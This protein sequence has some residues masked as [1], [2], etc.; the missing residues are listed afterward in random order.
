MCGLAGVFH[1]AGSDAPDD[2]EVVR[3]MTRVLAHRGP[4]DEGFYSAPRIHLGHRRLS[5]VDLLPTGHQP[6]ESPQGSVIA[7]NGECY[8]HAT[9]RRRLAASGCAFRGTSDTETLLYALDR[10]GAQAL[11]DLS[12]IFAFAYW[13]ARD[14]RLVLARDPLGVKQLYYHDDGSRVVFASEIKALLHYP[15]VPIAPD[16]EGLNEYLHFHTTLFDRSFFKDIRQVRPGEWLE[17]SRHGLRHRF[18]WRLGG[19]EPRTDPPETQVAQ[20]KAELGEVV[21]QQ[22]M[23]D[24]PVGCFFSGGIDSTA[25]AAVA[26]RRSPGLRGFGVHFAGQ[27]VVDERPFQESAAKALGIDL[28]LMTLDGSTFP[29]DLLRLSYFQD[30]PVIGA[31]MVP[32]YHVSR[33]AAAS[34]KVCLGGQ[35]GDELFG[36]YARYALAGLSRTAVQWIRGAPTE[37]TP[38]RQDA[39]VGGN[40]AAQGLERRNLRRLAGN[41]L[42]HRNWRDRYFAN[43]AT[44][45]PAIWSRVFDGAHVHSRGAARAAF[46]DVLDRSPA[47]DPGSKLIHWDAQTYLPGLFHQDDRMSM[48]NSLESRVPLADPRLFRFAL[49]TPFGLK[50]RDGASKWILRRAVAGILPANVLNRRKVGFDTPAERWM[51]TTHAGFVRDLLLSARA[52]QRGYW[53]SRCVEQL[54]DPRRGECRFDVL[55]KLVSIEAWATTFIDGNFPAGA[56]RL[57]HAA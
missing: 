22:L 14:G 5:I 45:P 54:L 12:G 19:C 6:M 57:T 35:G 28:S 2:S 37:R 34:V 25:I 53:N 44:V 46:D 42:A 55:W 56:P 50:I 20:L 36:G 7:Y 1:Y 49:Q 3:R 13:S 4:D 39:A 9:L 24:V 41:V 47:S 15:G 27:G 52:R 17:V 30:A 33:L 31:A 40:L 38:D 10:W 11:E 26:L 32:M 29:E 8:S 23:S 43:F 21:E 16:A 51:R 48:A 18:F